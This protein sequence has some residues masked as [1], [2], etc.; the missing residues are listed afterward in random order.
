MGLQ[1]SQ[2]RGM[3]VFSRCHPRAWWRGN[4][5]GMIGSPPCRDDANGG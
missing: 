1:T 3:G 5:R 4:L 2:M